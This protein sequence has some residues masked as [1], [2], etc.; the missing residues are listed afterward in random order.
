MVFLTS[1]YFQNVSVVFSQGAA[2]KREITKT[3]INSNIV[4]T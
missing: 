4:F 1:S 2:E 3:V